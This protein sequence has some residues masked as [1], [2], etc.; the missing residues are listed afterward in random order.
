MRTSIGL[1][2]QEEQ[3]PKDPG[4]TLREWMSAVPQAPAD[5]VGRM[6]GSLLSAIQSPKECLVI[7]DI[8]EV[9]SITYIFFK[10]QI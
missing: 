4:L 5:P 9:F 8:R 6:S 10:N 1:E 3:E 7:D 2:V